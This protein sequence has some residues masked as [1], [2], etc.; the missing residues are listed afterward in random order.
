MNFGRNH[1][2][3]GGIGEELAKIK[4]GTFEY[5]SASGRR[6]DDARDLWYWTDETRD[7]LKKEDS[8]EFEW[9]EDDFVWRKKEPETRS[10]YSWFIQIKIVNKEFIVYENFKAKKGDL[11]NFSRVWNPREGKFYVRDL[12]KP[13]SFIFDQEECIYKT[14]DPV[15]PGQSVNG[16]T[17]AD[18][19]YCTDCLMHAYT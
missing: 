6:G 15:P 14:K 7:Y 17:P 5:P 8:D 13:Y 3:F 11:I 16:L 18:Y 19:Y 2:D 10:P 1:L 9:C 12:S 4:N